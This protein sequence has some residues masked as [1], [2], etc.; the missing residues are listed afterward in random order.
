MKKVSITISVNGRETEGLV[1]PS[2]TLLDFLRD[3]L[4]MTGTKKGC[5]SGECGACTVILDGSPVNACLVLAVDADGAQVT[6][7][8]G[9][10]MAGEPD[11][12]QKAFMDHGAIQCGYCTPGMIMSATSLLDRNP[13]P[14]QGEIKTALSGNL[15][16]CGGYQKIMDAVVAAAKCRP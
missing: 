14:G 16:R 3:H 7:I 10:G 4:L 11:D 15:C 8:E 6:T 1:K 12:I 2:M 13:N 5:D 9:L